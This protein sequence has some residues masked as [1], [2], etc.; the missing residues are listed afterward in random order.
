[1]I[2]LLLVASLY[3]VLKI[4]VGKAGHQNTLNKRFNELSKVYTMRNNAA[5]LY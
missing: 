1:M 5:C 2:I 4:I 3:W